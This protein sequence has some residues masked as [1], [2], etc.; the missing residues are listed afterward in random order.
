MLDCVPMGGEEEGGEDSLD[1][2]INVVKDT[3]LKFSQKSLKIP[4]NFS[5]ATFGLLKVVKIST[6]KNRM[7]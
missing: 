6:L 7:F 4:L 2:Y 3:G 1:I 5:S